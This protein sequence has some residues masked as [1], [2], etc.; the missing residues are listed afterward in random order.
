M[1]LSARHLLRIG[2]FMLICPVLWA[3]EHATCVER[4]AKGDFLGWADRPHCLVNSFAQSTVLWL[5]DRFSDIPAD[6]EASMALR[7]IGDTYIDETGDIKLGARLRARIDLPKLSRHASLIFE[8]QSQDGNREETIPEQNDFSLGL[9]WILERM[10]HWQVDADVGLRSGPDPYLR[11]RSQYQLPISQGD[12]LQFGGSIRYSYH[13]KLRVIQDLRYSHLFGS[14]FVGQ[15][16]HILDHRQEDRKDGE[17]WVRGVLLSRSLKHTSAAIGFSEEG[18]THDWEE[19][20]RYIWMRYRRPAYRDWLFFEFE[21]RLAQ[22]QKLNW[23][24]LASISFRLEI[25]FGY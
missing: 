3:D 25:L 2:L 11:L 12:Q 13:D 8:D 17:Y 21:P 23:D 22:T 19:R 1:L 15:L 20:S 16:F 4:D 9:R 7:A 10:E 14:T 24:T 18:V 6:K 5:D